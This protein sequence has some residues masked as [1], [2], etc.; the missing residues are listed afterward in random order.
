ML[1]LLGL[2]FCSTAFAQQKVA[3][4]T[5]GKEVKGERRG[6]P[7]GLGIAIG[8]PTGMA[9]KLWFGDWMGLQFGVGGD[10]GRLGDFST[11]MD[12]VVH[13][14]PFHTSTSEYS[15]PLHFGGG[16]VVSSNVTEGTGM[17]FLGPRAVAG[18]SVLVR[19]LPVDLFFEVA[20]TLLVYEEFTWAVDGQIGLRYYFGEG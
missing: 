17:I 13:A 14:R 10:L 12:F 5:F 19:E 3:T 2:V 8:A 4:P 18:V 1:A 15:V 6:G 20:P 11:N 16:M 9:G 7:L